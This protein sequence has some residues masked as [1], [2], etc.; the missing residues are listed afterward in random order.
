MSPGCNGAAAKLPKK[1]G[2]QKLTPPSSATAGADADTTV[3]VASAAG[4]ATRHPDRLRVSFALVSATRL[5]C[6]VASLEF[7]Q[8]CTVFDFGG[9]ANRDKCHEA[10]GL[11]LTV[12]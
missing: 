5:P 10:V 1:P 9:N 8:E 12:T 4:A 11:L 3:A 7:R 6:I 2:I